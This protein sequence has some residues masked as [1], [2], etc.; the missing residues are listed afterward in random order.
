MTNYKMSIA[1]A[2]RPCALLLAA[3]LAGCAISPSPI[4][5]EQRAAQVQLD[6]AA[7]YRDQ[8]PLTAPLTLQ[9]AMA[10][11]VNYNLEN[12]VKLMEQALAMGQVDLARYDMLPRLTAA[13]GYFTRNNDLVTDSVDV[14]TRLPVLSNT[15]SQERTHH[16][17]DLSL[18]WNVLDFGVSYYQAHQQADRSLIA[19]ERQRKTL[20]ALIQQVRQAY[21]LAV[22]AQALEGRVDPLLQ[23]VNR[24]LADAERV[25]A[26]KL[27]PPLETLNYRKA[28]LDIVRQLE[29]IRDELTQ[30]K[31]RLA[32]LMNLAPGTPY[33]LVVPATLKTPVLPLTL[34]GMEE[35]ALR[36]RP[37]LY[38]A[39]LQERISAAEAKKAVLRMLPGVELSFGPHYD[40][41][42]FLH[43][44]NWVDAGLRVTWNLFNLLSGPKQKEIAEAQVEVARTQR[45][46]LSMAVLTQV[47]VSWQEFQGRQRQYELAQKL[48]EI[49]DR[50]LEH[51]RI[52]AQNDA[53]SRLNEIRSGVSALMADYRRYQNY[54]NLQTAYGQAIASVGMDPIAVAAT[55]DARPDAGTALAAAEKQD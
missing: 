33:S 1:S 28:M 24:A 5:S 10:R 48:W 43:N 38:E 12:R 15:T 9:A 52:G 27:R 50:I 40:S 26:E 45:L 17:F 39:D 4:T 51:T 41:N 42:A 18:T 7:M 37:E 13:A 35:R 22:G 32:S 54:A 3:L 44:N 36:E 30:A 47:H 2:G 20:H 19:R 11:A 21:W 23:Q 6:R 8:E 25:E 16:T 46:A 55:A 31:P 14:N 34:D 53:Q 49:D 29:A